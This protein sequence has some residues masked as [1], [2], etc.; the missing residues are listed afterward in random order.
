MRQEQTA[1]ELEERLAQAEAALQEATAD[2]A[3]V[4][5]QAQRATALEQDLEYVRRVLDDVKSSPSWR[6]TAPL[7]RAKN[8]VEPRARK[9]SELARKARAQLKG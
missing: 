6:V 8:A 2:R 4:W 7:R 9:A 5:E 3:R 1:T